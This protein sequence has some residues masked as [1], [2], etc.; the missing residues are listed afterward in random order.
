[1][2]V[3]IAIMLLS[4]NDMFCYFILF[5]IAQIVFWWLFCCFRDP[6]FFKHLQSS[7][8]ELLSFSKDK[9]LEDEAQQVDE[10]EDDEEEIE[11]QDEE[12]EQE[13]QSVVLTSA[14]FQLL[15][16]QVLKE[17][18]IRALKRLLTIFRVAAHIT[19]EQKEGK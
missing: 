1:M 14:D 15:K 3:D 17:K 13:G 2:E 10:Q 5:L 7:D 6:S 9:L 12:E 11:Q 16:K 8:K 18:S 4:S 19:D